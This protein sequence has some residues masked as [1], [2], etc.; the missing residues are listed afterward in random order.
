MTDIK[1]VALFRQARDAAKR[2]LQEV[3][4]SIGKLETER[5]SL[6]ATVAGLDELLDEGEPIYSSAFATA[7]EAVTSAQEEMYS[8]I[9]AAFDPLHGMTE[10]V[11][12]IL[13]IVPNV[14]MQAA[15][16]AT[17]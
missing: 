10:A 15:A 5:L 9:A 1:D 6:Q 8:E 14:G 11:R 12:K 17:L 3:E 13:N 2:R 7:I 16:I 4:Q